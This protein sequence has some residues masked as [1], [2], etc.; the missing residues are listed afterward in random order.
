MFGIKESA[1]LQDLVKKSTGV[2]YRIGSEV[3]TA[4]GGGL[5]MAKYMAID[6]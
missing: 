2:T 3:L 5:P 6:H 1:L 4:L